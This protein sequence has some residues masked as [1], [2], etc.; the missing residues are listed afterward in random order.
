M[1]EYYTYG[2]TLIGG[3]TAN[4]EDVAAEFN[5][6]VAGLDKLPTEAQLKSGQINY[7]V[8][9]G[10]ANTYVVAMPQTPLSL[11]EGY[12]LTFKVATTNTTT[13]TL[14]VDGLGAKSLVNT[15]GSVLQ[16]GDLVAG[17]MVTVVYDGTKFQITSVMQ[18]IINT[19][20]AAKD[21]AVTA[22]GLAETAQGLAEDA[23]AA[24]ELAQG[25]AEDANT[26]AAEWANKA[27]DSPVS[28]AAGGDASTTFSAMHWAN[29]A[30]AEATAIGMPSQAGHAGEFLTT[31]GTALSFAVVPNTLELLA[32]TTLSGQLFA[33]FSLPSGYSYYVLVG[34]EVQCGS[35]LNLRTSDDGG[36]TF[37]ASS[38]DY[39]YAGLK[40]TSASTTLTAH[41]G[42]VT[43]KITL[44]SS[45][46]DVFFIAHISPL[47]VGCNILFNSAQFT[48]GTFY[49]VNGGGRCETGGRT[50][51]VRIFDYNGA[52]P[53]TSGTL[54]LYGVK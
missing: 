7:A 18:G 31:N 30:E 51:A 27:E 48:G 41:R 39:S 29:K 45:G 24:A 32:T 36:A 20:V 40:T 23:Q 44:S 12:T 17:A 35:Y 33:D 6:I 11:A 47:S 10:S 28:I 50:D 15:D 52:T 22:Q 19:A 49:N 21:A 14:N 5:G 53:L 8:D 9:A 1:N 26:Y 16:A 25:S 54:K 42:D 3:T 4:A 37:Y 43:G 38:A 46:D 34:S 13:S 2:D